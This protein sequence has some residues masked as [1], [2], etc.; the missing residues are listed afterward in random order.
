M[1]KYPKGVESRNQILTET[2]KL[3]NEKGLNQT[4]D[5]L[6]KEMGLSRGKITNYFPT[7]ESLLVNIMREYEYAIGVLLKE[8]EE[9]D[10]TEFVIQYKILSQILDV[11]YEYRCA[12][13][14]LSVSGSFQPEIH[15]HVESSFLNRLEGIRMR[16]NAMVALN[17]LLPGILKQPELDIYCF[18]YTTL[19]TTWVVCQ[20]MY[21]SRQGFESMKPVYLRGAMNLYIPWL[22]EKGKSEFAKL[23][24]N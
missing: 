15:Q 14:Y 12:I 17:L 23:P 11:Q 4:M 13:A 9:E 3:L 18:Q 22:T 7:K 20:E 2:R 5:V 6:A 24:K 8:N 19:L 10:Q 1:N 21:Y 16:L